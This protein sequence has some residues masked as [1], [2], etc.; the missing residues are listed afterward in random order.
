MA[1]VG[2]PLIILRPEGGAIP[3]SDAKA[4]AP[5]AAASTIS[6]PK[7]SSVA[8]SSSSLGERALASPAVRRL[9]KEHNI[10]I[11]HVPASGPKSNITKED[12]LNFIAGGSKPIASTVSTVPSSG[13]AP[14]AVSAKAAP[15]KV[16]APTW[17]PEDRVVPV[18]G[19]QRIMVYL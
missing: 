17:T 1:Q 14:S 8:S 13:A 7:S 15:A 2:Q 10:D 4:D 12:I 5:A 6:A 16:A 9:A 19:I 18:T 11:Q 3:T